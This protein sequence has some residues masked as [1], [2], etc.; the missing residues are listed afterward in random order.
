[1]QICCVNEVELDVI[2]VIGTGRNLEMI[3]CTLLK[4]YAIYKGLQ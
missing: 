1:M 4:D 2:F 3:H